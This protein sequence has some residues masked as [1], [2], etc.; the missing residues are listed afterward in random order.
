MSTFGQLRI[1]TSINHVSGPSS[2]KSVRDGGLTPNSSLHSRK[3]SRELSSPSR[4][5]IISLVSSAPSRNDSPSSAHLPIPSSASSSVTSM[6]VASSSKSPSDG[7]Q[8]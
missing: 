7:T 5:S 4:S 2:S 6:S 1:D 3:R 8:P